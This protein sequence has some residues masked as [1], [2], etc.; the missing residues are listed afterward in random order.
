MTPPKINRSGFKRQCPLLGQTKD[1]NDSSEPN[2]RDVL[3][4]YQ[5][6][7][8]KLK[9]EKGKEPSISTIVKV[10]T[11]RVLFAYSALGS[12]QPVCVRYMAKLIIKYHKEHQ[13]LTK[14]LRNNSG[15]IPKGSEARFKDFSRTLTRNIF[16]SQ[17]SAN[18]AKYQ[19]VDPEF[20][21]PGQNFEVETNL[22]F[23][24][25]SNDNGTD[26]EVLLTETPP[27]QFTLRHFVRMCD[28]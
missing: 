22:D 14:L 8:N 24:N 6:V 27:P 2:L 11:E 7:L 16:T 28:R 20:I 10:V 26:A 12:I 1:L 3:L 21:P 19:K 17:S 4:A 13:T 5:F 15:F 23:I 9:Q 25:D 18:D